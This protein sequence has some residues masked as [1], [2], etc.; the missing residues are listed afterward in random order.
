[1]VEG[2]VYWLFTAVIVGTSLAIGVLFGSIATATAVNPAGVLD[3]LSKVQGIVIAAIGI[4]G[5]VIAYLAQTRKVRSDERIKQLEWIAVHEAL[6]HELDGRILLIASQM[7][8]WRH[9]LDKL[10]VTVEGPL[11]D[12]GRTAFESSIPIAQKTITKAWGDVAKG[13]PNSQAP[14]VE[15]IRA[16]EQ[17]VSDAEWMTKA[18]NIADD[19]KHGSAVRHQAVLDSLAT[20][21]RSLK[22]N[23][24][25]EG[26]RRVIELARAQ[27]EA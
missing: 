2:N 11:L 25:S 21:E 26:A 6:D 3:S 24:A 1:M 9:L 4:A 8:G 10:K 17:L 14:M 18:L 12:I 5:A 16:L 27:T 19:P 20:Y 13:P 23:I 7:E 15:K 22:R